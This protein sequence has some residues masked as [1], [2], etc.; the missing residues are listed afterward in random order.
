MCRVRRNW[1]PFTMSPL[2]SGLSAEPFRSQQMFC[3]GD[4]FKNQR[5]LFLCPYI[6]FCSPH[7][8]SV[9]W[10]TKEVEVLQAQNFC[11][12]SWTPQALMPKETSWKMLSSGSMTPEDQCVRS[13][14]KPI[15]LFCIGE[16]VYLLKLRVNSPFCLLFIQG[17]GMNS[18]LAYPQIYL[19]C[20]TFHGLFFQVL[21]FSPLGFY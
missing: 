21:S 5:N 8:L 3:I 6:I 1:T 9:T 13:H 4:L 14:K 19:A 18:K 2:F 11:K 10:T 15:H 17:W 7:S 16:T 20:G 12:S